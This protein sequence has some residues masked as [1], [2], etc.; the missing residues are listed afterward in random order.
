MAEPTD[1][2]LLVLRDMRMEVAEFR[3]SVETRL[4]RIEE[5]QRGFRQALSADSMMSRLVTGDFEERIAALEAKV[6]ALT[7]VR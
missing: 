3:A 7:N 4:D 5:T 6:D 2:V 1:M